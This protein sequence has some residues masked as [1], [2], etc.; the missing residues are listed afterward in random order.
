MVLYHT[1]VAVA[2]VVPVVIPI[3]VPIVIP[4]V[5]IIAPIPSVISTS[6]SVND[7]TS[8]VRR[9]SSCLTIVPVIFTVSKSCSI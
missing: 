6:I 3:I 7:N 2:V 4:I 1:L 8:T 5:P 9:S